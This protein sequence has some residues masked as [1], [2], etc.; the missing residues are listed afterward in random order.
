[1][2]IADETW[3]RE[4]VAE[5]M[6]NLAF[7]AGWLGKDVKKYSFFNEVTMSEAPTTSNYQ[8]FANIIQPIAK[9]KMNENFA[10]KAALVRL[11]FPVTIGDDQFD[12]LQEMVDHLL[13]N[14]PLDPTI[15][16]LLVVYAKKGACQLGLTSEKELLE[17]ACDLEP[18]GFINWILLAEYTPKVEDKLTC[19]VKAFEFMPEDVEVDK[20]VR[21]LY[22]LACCLV[23]LKK[24]S[25]S[26]SSTNYELID[27]LTTCM[28]L[29]PTFQAAAML[30][31]KCLKDG[32]HVFQGQDVQLDDLLAIY[33]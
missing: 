2:K 24:T 31:M 21:V 29:D 17:Y 14:I 6:P 13:M 12:E 33:L 5:A 16:K 27:I 4:R 28:E 30:Y 26:T 10:F 25:F 8:S 1:M 11:D 32:K 23:E 18:Y 7:A 9:G 20:K 22:N 3:T 19:Y 15:L